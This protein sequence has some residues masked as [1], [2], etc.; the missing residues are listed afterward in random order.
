MASV[1][2]KTFG[3][4]VGISASVLCTIHCVLLP[5]LVTTLPVFGIEVLENFWLEIALLALTAIIGGWA[6]YRGFKNYNA[7]AKWLWWFGF[8]MLA[9]TLGNFVENEL[10]EYGLKITA[11]I[12][13]VRAHY[14]NI[15]H[16]KNNDCHTH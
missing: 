9:L 5:L 6:I 15:I 12:A 7:S 14:G 3:D 13:I 11:T 1:K 8:G 16:C 10:L 4:W 2:Y